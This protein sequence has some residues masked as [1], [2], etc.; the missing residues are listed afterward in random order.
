[1]AKSCVN[2]S[3]PMR[4]SSVSAN[5]AVDTPIR[6]NVHTADYNL[7]MISHPLSLGIMAYTK[8]EKYRIAPEELKYRLLPLWWFTINTLRSSANHDGV[9]I[10]II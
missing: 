4:V 2:E 9:G 6:S 5:P 10:S 1:M 8:Q 3:L 7:F